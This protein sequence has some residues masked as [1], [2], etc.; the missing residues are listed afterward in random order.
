M[1][2]PVSHWFAALGGMPD[3]R[4]SLDGPRSVDVC[5]VGGGFTGLWTA[6][7]LLRADPSLDVLV[8]E[9][10]VCGFGA[11]GRNGGWLQGELAGDPAVWDARRGPGGAV[12][13]HHA[14]RDTVAVVERAL[15][16]D[17]IDC[18]LHRGGTLHVAQTPVEL[19]RLRATVDAVRAAGGWDDGADAWLDGD[20][21][22]ARV[23]IRGGRGAW[24][25][26]AC[27]RLQPAKL[28]RG[29]ATAVERAGATIVE[30][31]T[32]TAIEPARRGRPAA[33]AGRDGAPVVVRTD[34]GSVTARWAVRATE[35]YGVGLA[36]QRRSLAP[37]NSSM[38]VTEPLADD[39]WEALGWAGQETIL[40]GG[41]LYHYLQRTADGRIAIGGRGV[42]Y[43]WGSRTDREGPVP[44]VTV[45]ELQEGL[46][47][48]FG[49]PLRD[50]AVAGAW[51]GVLGIPRDWTPGV[52]AD[53]ATGVAWAGGYVGE[54]VAAA[55][56][57]GRTLADLL[58]GERTALTELAW[59]LPPAAAPPRWE[60]EP[61]RWLGIRSVYGLLGVAQA[62]ERRTGR[63]SR[64]AT[65]ADRLS[66]R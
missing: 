10:D 33:G 30:G 4:P 20:G 26:S 62:I 24:A 9:R 8:V 40:D 13:M 36:G 12:A 34:R 2:A 44:Q 16:E 18:D 65:V 31:T 3:P 14:I 58:R 25:S 15:A 51:H 66:G 5:V 52:G 21:L 32:V 17:G 61:L 38:I 53:P 6:R 19:E 35:A 47:R 1:T 60:P 50:V 55:N 49:D 48:L 39:R 45:R 22:A 46:V 63:P 29:L 57:A 64:V 54:G 42:P 11:S 27:A 23:A 56:L 43:R 7:E 59:V 28:V 37:V 41:L